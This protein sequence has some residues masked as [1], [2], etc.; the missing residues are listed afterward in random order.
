VS[1]TYPIFLR[2]VVI[3]DSNHTIRMVENGTTE[4][5]TI[6]NGTYYLGCA[7]ADGTSL[8][9]VLVTALNSHVAG[10][11]TY[12][13]TTAWSADPTADQ[14]VVTIARA[15]GTN[16]FQ[17]VFSHANNT[18]D[19]T[20]LGFAPGVDTSATNAAKAS[21]NS[22]TACWVADQPNRDNIVEIEQEVTVPRTVAGGARSIQHGGPYLSRTFEFRFISEARAV[23]GANYGE[24]VRTNASMAMFINRCAG[25]GEFLVYEPT[26]NSGLTLNEPN[27]VESLDT[28]ARTY[29]FS[30]ETTQS[31]RPRRLEPGVALYDFDVRILRAVAPI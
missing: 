25:G 18:F 30:E 1:A 24:N 27:S 11:N 8:E 14:V 22:P 2:K 26:I 9:S 17:L 19:E 7:S 13:V 16:T 10:T 28:P 21:T 31:F 5:V 15:T 4:D 12:A 23:N 6:A 3:D 29:M 20:I